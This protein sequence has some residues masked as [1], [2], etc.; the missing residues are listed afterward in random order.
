MQGLG[1]AEAAVEGRLGQRNVDKMMPRCRFDHNA[2]A[3]APTAAPA[4][5]GEPC[6]Q[7]GSHRAPPLDHRCLGWR[8]P[9]SERDDA[10]CARTLTQNSIPVK[11]GCV[12]T[13]EVPGSFS[14]DA[15][16][17]LLFTSNQSWGQ[18][19]RNCKA[20]CP[21]R[22]GARNPYRTRRGGDL[23]SRLLDHPKPRARRAR[24]RRWS[25]RLRARR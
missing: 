15:Q 21:P 19:M 23:R 7:W 20:R 11:N 10:R 9:P 2:P 6:D 5:E 25:A 3:T 13:P 17:H 22:V 24:G 12:W 8:T 4:I 18:G 1:F 16:A 14:Q